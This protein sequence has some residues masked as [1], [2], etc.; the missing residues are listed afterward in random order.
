M[1][2]LPDPVVPTKARDFPA[3]TLKE[4]LYNIYL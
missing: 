2:D 4:I 1:V 3:G